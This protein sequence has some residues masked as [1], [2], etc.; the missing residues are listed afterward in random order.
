MALQAIHIG[1]SFLTHLLH[2]KEDKNTG[3]QGSEVVQLNDFVLPLSVILYSLQLHKD[4]AIADFFFLF[5]EY[6]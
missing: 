3:C 6:A 4:I 2:I 1:E 5:Q